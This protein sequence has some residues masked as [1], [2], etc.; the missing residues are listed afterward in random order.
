MNRIYQFVI[1]FVVCL[2]VLGILGCEYGPEQNELAALRLGSQ[3]EGSFFLGCGSIG[4]RPKIYYI[5]KFSDG[6]CQIAYCSISQA[7]IYEDIVP[8]QQPY[9]VR[10]TRRAA[11]DYEFHIPVGAIVYD[12]S[13]NLE[14]LE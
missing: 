9:Y 11:V 8:P 12:F 4:D 14:D 6:G 5:K 7:T 13:V 3:A 2:S 1:T 10:D